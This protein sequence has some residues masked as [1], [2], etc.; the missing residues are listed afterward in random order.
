MKMV[1]VLLAA[2]LA[3]AMF[4]VSAF[5]KSSFDY[6]PDDVY[7][8][9]WAYKPITDFLY[10]DIIDGTSEYDAEEDYTYVWVKPGDQITRAQFT[11]I[12]VNALN[13][14]AVGT[15]KTFS[16]VQAKAWYAPYVNIASSNGIIKGV[17]DKF[18]PT[19]TITREQMA[20]MIYR[21]FKSTITF[22][23]VTKTFV[24]VKAGTES[25]E[26][27]TNSAANGIIA[28]FGAQFKPKDMATR[29]QGIAM[30]HR[31][32]HQETSEL[33]TDEQL[34]TLITDLL[35][36]EREGLVSGNYQMDELYKQY[37]TGFYLVS[38]TESG[39]M[40]DEDMEEALAHMKFEAVG[41]FTVGTPVKNNRYAS[42]PVSNLKYKFTYDDGEMGGY[43]TLDMSGT[44]Q[45]KK[46]AAGNWKIFNFE[47]TEFGF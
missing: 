45:L 7:D 22:K 17:G 18:N 21:A 37:G 6:M 8:D 38:N 39:F 10:A 40:G 34:T 29:A 46:D 27:I 47:Y 31:A 20:L 23:P 1:R 41:E 4:P 43:Q 30:I 15:P 42:V 28:G 3:V 19:A 16:D 32:L 36:K 24:D 13:L 14:K 33:P 9:H 44:A 26:A 5:A 2:V 25:Y 11:K 12:M 35:T